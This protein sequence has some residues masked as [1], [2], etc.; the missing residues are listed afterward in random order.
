[1]KRQIIL[2]TDRPIASGEISRSARTLDYAVSLTQLKVDPEGNGEGLLAL[3][4]ELS[5]NEQQR[6]LELKHYDVEP[7]RLT[8][9]RRRK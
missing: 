3:A 9:V 1:G 6:A 5:V 7:L 8:S 2:A 4:V